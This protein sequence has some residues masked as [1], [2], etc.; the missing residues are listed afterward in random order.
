MGVGAEHRE[1]VIADEFLTQ[2]LNEDMLWLY[3]Q[4]Q[5]LFARWLKLFAL[6][7]ICR[8]R[9]HFAAIGRVQPFQNDGSVEAA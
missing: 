1:H 6:T 2:V 4:Q 5:R 9:D 3:A 8:E 7:Q